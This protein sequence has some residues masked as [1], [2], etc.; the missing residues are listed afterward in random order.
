MNRVRPTFIAIFALA[1]LS[2]GVLAEC[3]RA[4]SPQF[5]IQETR[6]E[7]SEGDQDIAMVHVHIKMK[8]TNDSQHK[9]ILSRMLPPHLD[10][11]IEDPLGRA[12]PPTDE[13]KLAQDELGRTPDPARF[14]TILQGASTLR[15]FTVSFFVS[16][17]SSRSEPAAPPP[18]VYVIS[19]TLS[20]W[21]YWDDI[22]RARHF[23]SMW[24]PYGVLIVENVKINKLKVDISVPQKTD[25]G[26]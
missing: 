14:E 7:W 10:I 25:A 8:F 24:Q 1:T 4:Q 3:T 20:T 5:A 15:E 23:Q 21:P 6:L 11:K 12:V 22:K 9:M 19:A 13:Y 2:F 26:D 16:R 18:G 17:N